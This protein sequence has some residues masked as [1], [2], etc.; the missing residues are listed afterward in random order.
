[1]IPRLKGVITHDH[2]NK[3]PGEDSEDAATGWG[4]RLSP[5]VKLF[6][7]DPGDT[8]TWGWGNKPNPR[9]DPTLTCD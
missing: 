3:L 2:N 8:S 1:M 7:E 6:E 9:K 4:T 5:K